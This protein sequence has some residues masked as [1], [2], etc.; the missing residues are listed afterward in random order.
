[1]KDIDYK[2]IKF[3]DILHWCINNGQKEW[4]V[5]K[6]DE[7]K[8][9]KPTEDNP[10]PKP[11]SISFIEVKRDFCAKFFPEKLP[12]AQ[13]KPKSMRELLAEAI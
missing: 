9:G 13:P 11:R 3:T 5:A 12:V 2:D 4:L 6:L 10:K 8:P 7:T 1:M